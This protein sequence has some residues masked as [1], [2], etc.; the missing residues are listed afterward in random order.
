MNEHFCLKEFSDTSTRSLFLSSKIE[1]VDEDINEDSVEISR[2]VH[3]D[4][5]RLPEFGFEI[6]SSEIN[7]LVQGIVKEQNPKMRNDQKM[8]NSNIPPSPPEA[9][10]IS[11]ELS[12]QPTSTLTSKG[13]FDRFDSTTSNILEEWP[14]GV[15]TGPYIPTS[16][17]FVLGQDVSTA[18]GGGYDVPHHRFP[19]KPPSDISNTCIHF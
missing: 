9:A 5:K 14:H 8:N 19:P 2:S 17:L 3:P 11:I 4:F 6:E 7:N 15:R 1:T 13:K 10:I 18:D 16:P 12:E